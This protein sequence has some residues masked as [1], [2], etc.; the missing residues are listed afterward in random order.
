[1]KLKKNNNIQLKIGFYLLLLIILLV[2]IAYI[3][4]D[5]PIQIN[6]DQRLKPWSDQF[7]LGTDDLG[8]DFLSS[9]I[10]GIFNSLMIGF[11]VV[12]F[13]SFSGV[14]LGLISGFAGG[15]I[16]TIIMRVVDIILSFPGIL[17]AIALISFLNSNVFCLI[18]ILTFSGWVS[19]ARI[20]R[21]EVL[22]YKNL[23]FILAARSYNAS[24]FR[25]IFFHFPPIILPLVI[26]QAFMGMGEV[27]LVESSLNFLGI[28]LG[29][30]IP[31]LGQLIDVGR[32][33]LFDRPGLV[34]VPGMVIFLL[35]LSFNLIGEGLRKY[36]NRYL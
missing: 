6:M 34:M 10:Y 26:V 19:Y 5:F 30:E 16:D 7:P 17:M 11:F 18:G 4:W 27:I 15:V 2:L 22:K 23:E 35:I 29:P 3:Y 21:G 12:L 14:V 13:S 32:G 8:R 20:I 25:I 24:F 9:V 1:M 31:T 33:H 28:G 36:Y